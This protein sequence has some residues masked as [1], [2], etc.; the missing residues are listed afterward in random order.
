MTPSRLG[1]KAV[2]RKDNMIS[3]LLVTA[4]IALMTSAC[5][6]DHS[7]GLEIFARKCANCHSMLNTMDMLEDVSLKERPAYLSEL[8]KSHP[9][10]I[11]DEERKLVIAVLSRARN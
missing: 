1:L 2:K 7:K 10:I 8:L 11:N 5:S 6:D 4:L 3:R 9:V